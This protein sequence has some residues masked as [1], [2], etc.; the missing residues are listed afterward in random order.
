MGFCRRSKRCLTPIQD[1]QSRGDGI[2]GSSYEPLAFNTNPIVILTFISSTFRWCN[3]R[4]LVQLNTRTNTY[5]PSL[6]T[7]AV[8]YLHDP[9]RSLLLGRDLHLIGV[10]FYDVSSLIVP[11]SVKRR[12]WGTMEKLHRSRKQA[13]SIE[14]SK[15]RCNN[16]LPVVTN[17][18]SGIGKIERDRETE[19]DF[20]ICRLL[21]LRICG[22]NQPS[23]RR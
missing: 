10:R 11:L 4:K 3:P 17:L 7:R 2:D 22:A 1:E 16:S 19:R 14:I 20:L 9:A 6:T 13:I 12:R 23:K 15:T 5:T 21:H 8:F 18:I